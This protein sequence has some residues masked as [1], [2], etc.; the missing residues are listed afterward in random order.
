MSF[1]IYINRKPADKANSLE[2]AK[3]IAESYIKDK[4][5]L[6]IE[7]FGVP[8]Q[9]MPPTKY[10][11]WEYEYDKNIWVEEIIDFNPCGQLKNK[12]V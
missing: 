2:E 11:R 6:M 9:E 12:I 1:W 3:K 8:A 10:R 7:R 4:H 5:A